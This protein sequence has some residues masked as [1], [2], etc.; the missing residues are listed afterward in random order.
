MPGR[1]R[2]SAAT[3][4]SH[5]LEES[6]AKTKPHNDHSPNSLP[7]YA[8]ALRKWL[9]DQDARYVLFV[10]QHI[11]LDRRIACC[12]G[13]RHMV[14]IRRSSFTKGTFEEP[15]LPPGFGKT[16]SEFISENDE[17]DDTSDGDESVAHSAAEAPDTADVETPTTNTAKKTHES[18]PLNCEELDTELFNTIVSTWEDDDEIENAERELGRSGVRLLWDITKQLAKVA[19]DSGALSYGSKQLAKMDTIEKAG[20]AAATVRDFN[21]FKLS[22]VNLRKTLPTEC[23]LPDAL[24]AHKLATAARNLG[25]GIAV[26]LDQ[27]LDTKGARGNLKLTKEAIV[28]VLGLVENDEPEERGRGL[29]G[30]DPATGRQNEEERSRRERTD[31]ERK[32]H[33]DRKWD[34]TKDKICR[35]CKILNLAGRHWNNDCRDKAK[36]KAA[37]KEAETTGEHG[38]GKMFRDDTSDECDEDDDDEQAGGLQT[39]S[40]ALFAASNLVS[41][42]QLESPTDLLTALVDNGQPSSTSQPTQADDGQAG[43]A[44]M[45]RFP[46]PPEPPGVPTALQVT[47]GSGSGDNMFTPGDPRPRSSATIKPRIYIIPTGGPGRAGIFYGTWDAPDHLRKVAEGT[48]A[49]GMPTSLKANTLEDAVARCLSSTDNDGNSYCTTFRGPRI[50][51]DHPDLPIGERAD[52]YLGAPADEWPA[53]EP[54]AAAL[55]QSAEASHDPTVDAGATSSVPAVMEPEQFTAWCERSFGTVPSGLLSP[56][57]PA[58]ARLREGLMVMYQL[59]AGKYREGKLAPPGATSIT[60]IPLASITS[61]ILAQAGSAPQYCNSR[62]LYPARGSSPLR[63]AICTVRSSLAEMLTVIACNASAEVV[64]APALAAALLDDFESTR[65]RAVKEPGVA[66]LGRIV[67]PALR[68]SVTDVLSFTLRLVAY[69]AAVALG[70]AFAPRLYHDPGAYCMLYL[71][72]IAIAC[73]PVLLGSLAMLIVLPLYV[74]LA[75]LSFKGVATFAPVVTASPRALRDTHLDVRLV[76]PDLS[77]H[78]AT[79]RSRHDAPTYVQL[80]YPYYCLSC[81]HPSCWVSRYSSRCWRCQSTST[82]APHHFAASTNPPFA[83][84]PPSSCPQQRPASLVLFNVHASLRGG[85]LHY[86][87]VSQREYSGSSSYL[88]LWHA[89][90]LYQPAPSHARYPIGEPTRTCTSTHTSSSPRSRRHSHLPS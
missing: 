80:H 78:G 82:P 49:R 32:G 4:D 63:A 5:T 3:D 23:P 8:L 71:F 44:N 51:D 90:G 56:S 86:F 16:L 69:T 48:P 40:S 27:A 35:W 10:E 25:P 76:V 22:L 43:R 6:K 31:R 62:T 30:R 75:R 12:R 2:A 41:F 88:S 14:A 60:D 39:A 84:T 11:V 17:D 37:L 73:L 52:V 81:L 87:A 67:S 57:Y 55:E 70:V 26:R 66:F 65:K 9:P 19:S 33:P 47:H 1:K 28:S 59:S 13:H 64:A 29:L 77:H 36:A 7:E 21:V 34:E 85:G 18:H 45:A 15:Y 72:P 79:T 68:S 61:F 42:D 38:V 83:C 46:A 74:T 24:F 58:R 50:I 54:A 20:I 89:S 53:V